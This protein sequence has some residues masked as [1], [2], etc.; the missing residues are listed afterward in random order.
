M[1]DALPVIPLGSTGPGG[2]QLSATAVASGWRH[3]CA[4]VGADQVPG[5]VGGRVKW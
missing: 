2:P 5:D 1:G 4:I 3:N